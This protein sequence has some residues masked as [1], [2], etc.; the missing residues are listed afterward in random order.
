MR[1]INC[2]ICGYTDRGGAMYVYT[3][4]NM[5]LCTTRTAMEDRVTQTSKLET[6][7]TCH[8]NV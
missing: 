2:G 6:V 7:Y 5:H 4:Y 3:T 1:V 8:G